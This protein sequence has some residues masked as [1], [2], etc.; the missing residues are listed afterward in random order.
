MPPRYP[1]LSLEGNTYIVRRAVPAALRLVVGK[2]ELIRSLKMGDISEA[3]RAREPVWREF[4]R[5][6]AD[7]RRGGAPKPVIDIGAGQMGLARWVL[8]EW[9]RPSSPDD[10]LHTSW[11]LSAGQPEK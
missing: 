11:L 5:I 9:G 1:G 8:R 7:A 6:V 2:R 3:R 4:N 10:A